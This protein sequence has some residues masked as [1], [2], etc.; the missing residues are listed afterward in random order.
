MR[1]QRYGLLMGGLHEFALA[2]VMDFKS[3]FEPL[4]YS[5]IVCKRLGEIRTC[6]QPPAGTAVVVI[7]H[8]AEP[9]AVHDQH[10]HSQDAD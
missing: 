10:S 5:V 9:T 7:E 6:E 4:D 2:Q 1:L 3:S 8:L